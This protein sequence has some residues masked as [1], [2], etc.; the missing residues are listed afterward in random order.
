MAN[1]MKSY[2][3]NAEAYER[4]WKT[5]SEQGNTAE[6]YAATRDYE[7][8]IKAQE[9]ELKQVDPNSR[10]Y[11]KAKRSIEEQKATHYEMSR[12]QRSQSYGEPKREAYEQ[13]EAKNT[14]L[15]HDMSKAVE[16]GDVAS[17]ES[18][19][20]QYEKNVEIQDQLGRQMREEGVKYNDT[21]RQS[22]Q[23]IYSHDCDM[24]DKMNAKVA[25]REAKGKSVSEEDRA[26]AEKY[27]TQV[28]KDEQELI[29]YNGDR[30]VESMR[31]RGASEEQIKAQEEKNKQD[32]EWVRKINS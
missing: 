28:K 26:A 12:E 25:E 7:K 24:R 1:R 2:Q 31:E 10:D 3:R 18:L 32:Q 15:S 13:L 30:T 11:E 14:Q 21:G 4:R 5:A 22:K 19:R 16:R 27:K 6:M 8:N 29:K 20:S 23:D 17:Y 9:E